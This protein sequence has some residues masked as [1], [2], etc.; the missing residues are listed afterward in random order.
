MG[1]I[2]PD[3]RRRTAMA[4]RR[5]GVAAAVVLAAVLGV[6]QEVRLLVVDQTTTVEESLRLQALVRGLKNT[7]VFAVRAMT[8]LPTERWEEEPFLFA[9]VFPAHGPYVWLLSPGP[10]EYLPDP[11]PLVYCRLVDG[12]AQA[13]SGA[14]VTRGSG[15]DLYPFLLSIHLQ[16]LGLLVGAN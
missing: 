4:R 11:L 7:G 12:V 8:A 9:L 14:R 1:R 5:W 2:T 15:D 10:I 13:F 16:R 3:V 6:S